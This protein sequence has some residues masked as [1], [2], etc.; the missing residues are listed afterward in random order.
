MSNTILLD[1]DES[2]TLEATLAFV[3][4][5]DTSI[6]DLT[7]VSPLSSSKPPARCLTP[8]QKHQDQHS[9]PK[10]KQPRRKYPNSSSTVLQRRKKAEIL[11]LRNQVE[12]LEV[13][14]AQLKKVPYVA[15]VAE[16][17]TWAQQA[18]VQYQ[19]RLQAEKTNGKLKRVLVNQMKV[20]EALRTLVQKT[21]MMDGMDFLHPDPCRPLTDGLYG[22]ELLEKKVERLYLDAD[23]V[24]QREKMNS[25]SVQAVE[26]QNLSQGKTVEI[27][28]T[29]PMMCP[30]Q[31]ASETLWKWFC[32]SKDLCA[33]PTTQRPL[34][35]NSFPVIGELEKMVEVQEASA[36]FWRDYLTIRAYNDKS[37]HFFRQRQPS[38]VEKNFTWI[39]DSDAA[40]REING[41][42]FVRKIEEPNRNGP[43]PSSTV[44]TVIQLRAE[45]AKDFTPKKEDLQAAEDVVLGFLSA[46]QKYLQRQQREFVEEAQQIRR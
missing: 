26:K 34:L 32:M 16:T 27:M 3:D 4:T 20:T 2:A 25:I 42:S 15:Y 24:F 8:Q 21:A 36:M 38:S 6:T 43:I 35:D 46:K 23:Q 5:F 10:P 9:Q 30:L 17:S 41:F 12:Q 11:A 40:V 44:H 39:L 14:L 45:Y 33:T 28:S 13:Q 37:Y 1:A 7:V 18:A 29:T 22:M 19:G 31:V